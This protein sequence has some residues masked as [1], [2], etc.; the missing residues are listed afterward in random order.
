MRGSER[1]V[2]RRRKLFPFKYSYFQRTRKSC[3]W[4]EVNVLMW[5]WVFLGRG[6]DS[7]WINAEVSLYLFLKSIKA[8]PVQLFLKCSYTWE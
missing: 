6:K 3:S 8:P 5:V 1:G 4:L 2:G 7:L